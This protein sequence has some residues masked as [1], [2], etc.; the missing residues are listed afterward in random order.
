[1]KYSTACKVTITF[2][3]L[4]PLSLSLTVAGDIMKDRHACIRVRLAQWQYTL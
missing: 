4:V 3:R 2:F 1:M